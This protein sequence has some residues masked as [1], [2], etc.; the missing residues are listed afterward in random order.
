MVGQCSPWID[1]CSPSASVRSAG[2]EALA[3]ELS[4]AAHLGL[5]TTLLPPPPMLLTPPTLPAPPVTAATTGS[6]GVVGLPSAATA[7][8]SG[9]AGCEAYAMQVLRALSGGGA[10]GGAGGNNGAA[11]GGR[12]P[13]H[14]YV[15]VP[16][17]MTAAGE[18]QNEGEHART[19]PA[20]AAA[21]S[22]S[23]SSSSAAGQRA[24][25]EDGVG[26]TEAAGAFEVDEDDDVE[27]AGGDRGSSS[28]LSLSPASRKRQRQADAE[29]ETTTG[30]PHSRG[31][32]H[33]AGASSSSSSPAAPT[34]SASALRAADDAPWETWNRIRTLADHSPSLSLCLEITD[35]LP[36]PAAIARWLGEPV[37]AAVLPTSLFVA[38]K[39]G[40][41]VLRARHQ[42]LVVQL[43]AAGVQFVLR[44]RARLPSAPGALAAA[45]ATTS[46]S[47]PS[48]SPLPPTSSAP[49]HPHAVYLASLVHVL[50]RHRALHPETAAH[51]F[52][53][54][55]ADRLQLPLQPLADNLEA[56]TY[57]V[58]ESDPAKYDAYQQA[59]QDRLEDVLD[60]D[61]VL[62][63]RDYAVVMV[64]G[65]GRGPLVRRSLLAA[66]A[67]GLPV[68][69]YAVEKNPNAV[70]TLRALALEDPLWR[71]RVT[72][73][74]GDMRAWARPPEKADVLVSELLGSF[75]DNELSPECLDG[76]ERLL[77]ARPHGLSVPA[78]YTSF[79]CPVSSHRVWTSVAAMR[80]PRY[81]ETPFVVR[82]RN[83]FAVA[84]TQELFTFRHPTF[85]E[86]GVEKEGEGEG[87]GEGAVVMSGPPVLLQVGPA[88]GASPSSQHNRRAGVLRFVASATALVHGFAGYFESALSDGV[89]LSNHPPTLTPDLFSWF[90]LFLPLRDP[91]LVREGETMEVR[92]WRCVRDG[93]AGAGG[94]RVWYEWCMQTAAGTTHLHNAGGRSYSI[95]M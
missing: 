46:S 65:A 83:A 6:A 64:V 50:R 85:G 89:L 86:G 27:G 58:F 32:P 25:G 21:S 42:R 53:E 72:V 3:A 26:A 70:I 51:R 20:A 22:S 54:G 94:G 17:P 14:S 47:S 71:G 39:A 8:S 13:P 38:N 73:V 79:L 30:A 16:L 68:R 37:K 87:E 12:G 44:G 76:A 29:G 55:Y 78:S 35:R 92:V 66:D 63:R 11:G 31:T 49:Q 23:S 40:F 45:A 52:V 34:S 43:H 4:L 7:A 15:W 36:R 69:V 24:G 67:L 62:D 95:G 84:P 77:L 41:P 18:M 56:G 81:F 57:E 91:V 90:P 28:S 93:A 5:P 61:G 19:S 74:A 1:V 80:E 88:P 33:A 48:P 9:W 2:E 60:M 75:G 82:L 59:V 10:G